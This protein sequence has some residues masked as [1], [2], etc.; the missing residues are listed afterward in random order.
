MKV[1]TSH[2]SL[3]ANK[4]RENIYKSLRNNLHLGKALFLYNY[5]N[6]YTLPYKA[7]TNYKSKYLQSSFVF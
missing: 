3:Y 2:V 1:V 5:Y 6:I 4:V 7:N